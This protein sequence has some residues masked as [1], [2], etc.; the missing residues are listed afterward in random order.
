MLINNKYCSFSVYSYVSSAKRHCCI[1]LETF[2]RL[3]DSC[4]FVGAWPHAKLHYQCW[5]LTSVLS[6]SVVEKPYEESPRWEWRGLFRKLMPE[7][8]KSLENQLQHAAGSAP[9][10]QE[11][12]ELEHGTCPL[13]GVRV[14]PQLVGG[15]LD[16]PQRISKGLHCLI[17]LLDAYMPLASAGSEGCFVL[18]RSSFV[19]TIVLSFKNLAFKISKV[20]FNLEILARNLS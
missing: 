18:L 19:D 4:A 17:S 14:D 9:L 6:L 11:W 12:E 8:A 3:F 20:E 5:S 2:S 1:I 10:M 13:E 7:I 16:Y 15:R